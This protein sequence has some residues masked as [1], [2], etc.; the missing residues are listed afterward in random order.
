MSKRAD[1]LLQGSLE[2]TWTQTSNPSAGTSC[3]ATQAALATGRHTISTLVASLRNNTAAAVTGVLTAR[4]NTS[5]GT[6]IG[7]VELAAAV[8]AVSTFN[9]PLNWTG[10]YGAAVV[11]EFG[12]PASSVTQKAT[13]AGWT[14]QRP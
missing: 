2:G 8:G 10:K 7:Q 9:A 1:Q 5:A 12:T 14:D 6:V 4:H 3:V 13:I 11:L